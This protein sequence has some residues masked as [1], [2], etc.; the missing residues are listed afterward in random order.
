M[1][2][3]IPRILKRFE[4]DEESKKRTDDNKKTALNKLRVY[5]E[6]TAETITHY[7]SL[8]K[9]AEVNE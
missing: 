5:K 4:K 7:K 8:G 2:V 9:Y 3:L 6:E 1:N